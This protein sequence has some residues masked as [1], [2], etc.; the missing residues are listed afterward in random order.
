MDS[1]D[2]MNGD[3]PGENN[4]AANVQTRREGFPKHRGLPPGVNPKPMRARSSRRAFHHDYMAPSFYMITSTVHPYVPALSTIPSDALDNIKSGE[5]ISPVLTPLGLA[6]RDKI[7]GLVSFRPEFE[8]LDYVIMP[9][10]IHIVIHVKS[11][12]KKMLGRELAGFFGSCSKIYCQ[13]YKLEEFRSLFQPFHDRIIYNDIQLQRTLNYVRDNPRRY[14]IKK[15]HPDLFRRYIHLEI[16]G[17]DYAAYGNIFLLRM[18]EIFPV[19]IHRRWSP[20]EFDDYRRKCSLSVSNGAVLISPAIHPVEKEIMNAAT[21]SGAPVIYLTDQ[22]YEERFKPK[23]RKFELCS[24][25]KL[26]LLAPWPENTGR[27]SGAGYS[28][29]HLMNELAALIASL[30]TEARLSIKAI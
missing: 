22:G 19:R 25:G 20:Y 9:D 5:I 23:G 11:R 13:I 21:E 16:A 8:I 17:R 14:L 29:F 10:H 27:K 7:E 26:L 15:R 12:L 4:S 24:E 18:P 2:D 30:S 6:I 1:F 28:E 3:N